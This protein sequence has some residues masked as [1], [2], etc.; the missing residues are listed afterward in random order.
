M[1]I[2]N[3][4]LI[5]IVFKCIRLIYYIYYYILTD[6][7][8]LVGIRSHSMATGGMQCEKFYGGTP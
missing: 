4:Y 2:N 8:T 5:N 7:I 6:P 3:A 1:Y